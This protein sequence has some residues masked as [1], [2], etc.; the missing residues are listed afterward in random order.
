MVTVTVG[1]GGE[2]TLRQARFRFS[3]EPGV[4]SNRLGENE[5]VR[6]FTAGSVR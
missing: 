6:E 2:M 1:V 3:I 5:I 4:C